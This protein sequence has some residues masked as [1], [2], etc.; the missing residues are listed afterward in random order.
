MQTEDVPDAQQTVHTALAQANFHRLHSYD[1]LE[2]L[3]R[4]PGFEYLARDVKLEQMRILTRDLEEVT[5]ID[6]RD[7]DATLDA[8]LATDRLDLCGIMHSI[9]IEGLRSRLGQTGD[10][11]YAVLTLHPDD[12]VAGKTQPPDPQGR[13]CN[14]ALHGRLRWTTRPTGDASVPEQLVA[15]AGGVARSPGTGVQHGRAVTSPVVDHHVIELA[16]EG[17]AP[18]LLHLPSAVAFIDA[19]LAVPGRRVLV[20]C[21]VGHSRSAS[22]AAAYLMHRYFHG[23][24]AR[25]PCRWPDAASRAE[26]MKSKCD[27]ILAWLKVKRPGVKAAQ[28]NNFTQ[29]LYAFADYLACGEM[30]PVPPAKIKKDGGDQMRDAA[31]MAFYNHRQRPFLN[32]V[33]HYFERR[34]PGYYRFPPEM[35]SFMLQWLAV[36]NLRWNPSTK[37]LESVECII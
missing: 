14:W 4:I 20:H 19:H 37:K 18:M 22:V 9:D 1:D 7:F 21:K 3:S 5:P 35:E 25:D 32:L 6:F 27:E 10:R 2:T 15:L 11:D 33:R 17:S 34:A 13:W 24:V 8:A 12:W 23:V 30:P 29:Q 28:K 16:D 36:E 26:H 31:L